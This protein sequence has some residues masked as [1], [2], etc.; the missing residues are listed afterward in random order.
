MDSR[1]RSRAGS[2]RD[3]S[4][5]IENQTNEPLSRGRSRTIGSNTSKHAI[6]QTRSVGSI[7]GWEK[8]I[9]PLSPDNT[10]SNTRAKSVVTQTHVQP[11][12]R[13]LGPAYIPS[14]AQ[15]SRMTVTDQSRHVSNFNQTPAQSQ[16]SQNLGHHASRLSSW[17]NLNLYYKLKARL[18]HY[19]NIQIH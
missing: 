2:S 5:Q 7:T 11:S 3:Q 17:D 12:I 1:S 18:H 16:I 14:F 4:F 15:P 13:A 9:V 10:P 6:V 19:T 8:S